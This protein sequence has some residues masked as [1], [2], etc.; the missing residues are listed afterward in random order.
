MKFDVVIELERELMPSLEEIRQRLTPTLPEAEVRVFSDCGG[1]ATPNPWQVIGVA[2]WLRGRSDRI[3]Q[4]AIQIDVY[5]LTSNPKLQV[6]VS[7]DLATVVDLEDEFEQIETWLF[8]QPVPVSSEAVQTIKESLPN[9][10]A[11]L[12]RAV[13]R[14]FPAQKASSVRSRERT[15][16][17]ENE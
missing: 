4:A 1:L 6:S 8:P 7:W 10:I 5:P 2:C 14:G 9:L 16:A 15:T 12:E 13:K 3:V 17:N 11:I